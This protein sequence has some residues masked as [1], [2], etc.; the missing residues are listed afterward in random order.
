[1]SFS[2][3]QIISLSHSR[4]RPFA[5]I[6]CRSSDGQEFPAHKV[7]LALASPVIAAMAISLPAQDTVADGDNQ[8]ASFSADGLP[9]LLFEEDSVTL[10]TILGL[11]YPVAAA[12]NFAVQELHVLQ[13][14][15]DA[16]KK[17][18]MHD[19]EKS[20]QGQWAKLAASDPLRAFLLAVCHEADVEAH[21]AAR[22]LLDR[23]ME[24]YYT[25]ILENSPASTYRDALLYHRSCKSTLGKIVQTYLPL[26]NKGDGPLDARWGVNVYGTPTNSGHFL[27]IKSASCRNE[28]RRGSSKKYVMSTCHGVTCLGT[29]D[30]CAPCSVLAG[31][32]ENALRRLRTQP[33]SLITALESREE[34]SLSPDIICAQC[35]QPGDQ[36][37]LRFYKT[38]HAQISNEIN[39]V[40][41]YHISGKAQYLSTPRR[42]YSTCPRVRLPWPQ[43]RTLRH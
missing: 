15:I 17:Y 24:E 25:P 8:S 14:V 29:Q 36:A 18:E 31:I 32:I 7:L 10:R 41:S 26:D 22:M 40:Y 23:I 21:C 11:C 6:V 34:T 27:P 4:T 16:V 9:I 1:M 19:I 5:D 43:C 3:P 33:G 30:A 38:L 35:S 20:L 28:Y 39:K 2:D 13:V 37:K 42:C 12:D